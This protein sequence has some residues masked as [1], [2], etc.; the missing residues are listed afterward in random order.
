MQDHTFYG[1]V[2]INTLFTSIYSKP[3]DG[4]L[5]HLLSGGI[6]ILDIKPVMDAAI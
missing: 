6:P 4:V 2:S 1:V 3:I 5:A